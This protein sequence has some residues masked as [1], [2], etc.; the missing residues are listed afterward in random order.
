M[1][2]QQQMARAMVGVGAMIEAACAGMNER[3]G[4]RA[5]A[6]MLEAKWTLELAY[7]RLANARQSFVLGYYREAAQRLR[8]AVE[9]TRRAAGV[10][11]A[12]R[13]ARELLNR[14]LAYTGPRS[15]GSWC[16]EMGVTSDE[17]DAMREAMATVAE[18]RALSDR[19]QYVAW[20]FGLDLSE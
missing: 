3:A 14:L 10:L 17:L 5:S 15:A 13:D 6:R 9:H 20:S 2:S 16:D 7:D 1:A 18:S 19:E 12:R 4:S 8:A 11:S